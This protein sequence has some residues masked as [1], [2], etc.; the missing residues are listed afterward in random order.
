MKEFNSV[1]DRDYHQIDMVEH[2]RPFGYEMCADAVKFVD[3]FNNSVLR[4]FV[5]EDDKPIEAIV[6]AC[7]IMRSMLPKVTGE[8]KKYLENLLVGFCRT[9]KTFPVFIWKILNRWPTFMNYVNSLVR[10]AILVAPHKVEPE[11]DMVFKSEQF[12]GKLDCCTY[13]NFFRET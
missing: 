11:R 6:I 4:S 12:F 7:W 2:L 8:E 10:L 5:D 13:F 1:A 3:S 9:G